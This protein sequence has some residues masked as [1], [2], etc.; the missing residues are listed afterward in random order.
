LQRVFPRAVVDV[1][2]AVQHFLL[3]FYQDLRQHEKERDIAIEAQAGD[4]AWA[5]DFFCKMTKVQRIW[6]PC[7]LVSA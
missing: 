4:R 2:H 3:A 5:V 1:L 6:L 7:S